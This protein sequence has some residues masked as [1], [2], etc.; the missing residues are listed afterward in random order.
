[1][2]NRR[3]MVVS[4][5]M[6]PYSKSGGLGDV[7]GALPTHLAQQGHSVTVMIPFWGFMRHRDTP[8]SEEAGEAE[9]IVEKTPY[10]VHFRRARVSENLSIVFIHSEECFGRYQV[11]MYA[12][13]NDALR[14]FIFNKAIICFL[15]QQKELPEIINC[16]DWHAG[17]IPNFLHAAAKKYPALAGIATVFTFHNLPF[18]MQGNWWA[19]P[20]D[21]VDDGHGNPPRELDRIRWTNFMRRG[22][23]YADIINTVSERYAQEVLTP[24]FGQG[25]DRLLTRRKR[26]LFGIING[27]DYTVFNP[28]FDKFLWYDYDWNRLDRKLLNKRKLQELAGLEQNDNTPLLGMVHRMSEQKGFDLIEKIIPDLM[29]L[30]AQIVVLGTGDRDY[31]RMFEELAQRY[32]KKVAFFTSPIGSLENREVSSRIYAGSDMFL[33]PSRY[34]PCGVSQLISL[35]YGSIPIVHKTGGLSDTVIDFDPRTG[36]GT[37]FV[38]T[39]YRPENLLM[40]LTRALENF[41]YPQVWEHLTWEA[42]RESYSWVMPAQKYWELYELAIKRHAERV[43]NDATRDH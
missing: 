19:V 23:A 33:M 43:S 21:K 9:I 17:L 5:E 3:I 16:H 34:E 24:E 38:F 1:M 10:R 28:L 18:Q 26:D 30:D 42:M 6:A 40:A 27:I 15:Q 13:N 37:G 39:H 32:P 36:R 7:V 22:I 20:G 25:L 4:A 8:Q 11:H 2:K 14:F 41:K 12:H 35:R 29:E 31:I